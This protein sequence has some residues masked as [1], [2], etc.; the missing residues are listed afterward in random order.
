MINKRSL[1]IHEHV[2]CIEKVPHGYMVSKRQHKKIKIFIFIV[3]L[4]KDHD[5][6]V[7]HIRILIQHNSHQ[8]HVSGTL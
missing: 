1:T 7:F 8:N 3:T 2:Q 6:A 4:Q 5:T